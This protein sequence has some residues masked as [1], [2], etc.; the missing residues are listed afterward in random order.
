MKKIFDINPMSI[1][2]VLLIARLAIGSLMLVHGIPKLG[3]LLSGEVIAFPGLFGLSPA[4]SLSLAVFSEVV[5]SILILVGLGTRLAVIPL[6]ITMLVAVFFIHLE[7]P[8]AMK[9]LG[10]HYLLVYV[11]LL[12]AGSGRFSVD[13][14]VATRINN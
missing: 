5:C 13:K 3:M 9:E 7:D 11:F 14:V 8:F 2:G 1:D 12:I 6:I 4:I 10:I